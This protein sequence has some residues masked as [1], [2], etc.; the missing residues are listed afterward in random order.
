MKYL[1]VLTAVSDAAAEYVGAMTDKPLSI[2]PN[3]IDLAKYQ[4]LPTTSAKTKNV[5]TLLYIGRL[6]RRKG[7]KYL[8]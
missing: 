1:D 2:I 6:E 4:K 8:L 7:V 3:G 5:K